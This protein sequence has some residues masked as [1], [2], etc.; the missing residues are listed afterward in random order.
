MIF[1]IYVDQ[2]RQYRWRLFAGNNRILADS[3][4]SYHHRQDCESAV[5]LI[6]KNAS[7]AQVRV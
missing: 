3:G 4:E 1:V 2:A 7:A 6:K 5:D